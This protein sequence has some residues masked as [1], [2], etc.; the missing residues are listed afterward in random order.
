[1][2]DQEL[3]D[4]AKGGPNI[5][6]ASSCMEWGVQ[7]YRTPHMMFHDLEFKYCGFCEVWHPVD[8]FHNNKRTWDGLQC[9]CKYA[10]AQYYKL[11]EYKND[12]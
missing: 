4:R 9:V 11:K 3:R 7:G 2:T 12:R 8:E 1:M 5:K 10:T 6:V